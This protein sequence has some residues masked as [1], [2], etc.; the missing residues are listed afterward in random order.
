MFVWLVKVKKGLSLYSN[1]DESVF[2]VGDCVQD[3][4]SMKE[5]SE[6]RMGERK[7]KG[8][9]TRLIIVSA[10]HQCLSHGGMRETKRRDIW[11]KA[12]LFSL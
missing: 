6:G 3:E 9:G 4:V 8:R 11:K 5:R 10:Q 2:L 12:A 7:R 1:L